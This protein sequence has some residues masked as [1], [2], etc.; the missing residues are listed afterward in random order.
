MKLKWHYYTI[1]SDKFYSLYTYCMAQY[2]IS[3]P[4]LTGFS[5]Y[6]A[7]EVPSKEGIP[8]GYKLLRDLEGPGRSSFALSQHPYYYCTGNKEDLYFHP[9]TFFSFY[10]YTNRNP[11]IYHIR[12]NVQDCTTEFLGKLYNL[13]KEGVQLNIDDYGGGAFEITNTKKLPVDFLQGVKYQ[14]KSVKIDSTSTRYSDRVTVDRH[15]INLL[16]PTKSGGYNKVVSVTSTSSLELPPNHLLDKVSCPK[17]DILKFAKRLIKEGIQIYSLYYHKDR[18]FLKDCTASAPFFNFENSKGVVIKYRYK[19]EESLFP[20][21]DVACVKNQYSSKG[22]IVVNNNLEVITASTCTL[23]LHKETT[24]DGRLYFGVDTCASYTSINSLREQYIVPKDAIVINAGDFFNTGEYNR[25]A[26]KY[27]KKS[28]PLQTK[29]EAEK[30]L[31]VKFGTLLPVE[32]TQYTNDQIQECLDYYNNQDY[33]IYDYDFSS[34]K[35]AK[36]YTA[37]SP[38]TR[39]GSFIQYLGEDF[40]LSVEK[41][42][43]LKNS[44]MLEFLRRMHFDYKQTA[45]GAIY[46]RKDSITLENI[47]SDLS[48]A[49]YYFP[50]IARLIT[51][52]LS[53]DKEDLRKKLLLMHL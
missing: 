10:Q 1:N 34:R 6:N 27:V 24:I 3:L 23:L 36:N 43:Y 17:K 40:A 51:S 12:I 28:L 30:A 8:Q 26:N 52:I 18:Y 19:N 41:V 37:I 9:D 44:E 4:H 11:D 20:L 32:P 47:L 38:Y 13:I 14:Y 7:I 50:G 53:L 45:D 49:N 46:I 5:T 39:K 48:A 25:D 22:E 33:L 15:N 16:L 21:T 31:C 2:Y 42:Q 35:A 29:D